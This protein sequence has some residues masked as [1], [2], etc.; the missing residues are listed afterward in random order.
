MLL[1]DADDPGASDDI[2]PL[3]LDVY[4]QLLTACAGS[5]EAS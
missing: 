3:M 2:A 5:A 1:D 4:Q